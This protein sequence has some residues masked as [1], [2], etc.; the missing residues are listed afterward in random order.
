MCARW[1]QLAQFYPLARMHYNQTYNGEAIEGTEPYN[2]EGQWGTI[3]KNSI[4]ARY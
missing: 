2:L 1:I 3:A 4:Y